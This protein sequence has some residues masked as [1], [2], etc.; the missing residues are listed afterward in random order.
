MMNV[1][2]MIDF[3]PLHYFLGLQVIQRENVVFISQRN[4]AEDLLRGFNLQGCKKA[5]TPMNI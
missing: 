2:E 1:F 5:A 4:Y 3:G